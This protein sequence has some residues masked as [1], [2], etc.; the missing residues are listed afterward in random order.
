MFVEKNLV[1][2]RRKKHKVVARSSA[3]AEFKDMAHGLCELIWIKRIVQDLGL[4]HPEPMMLHCDNK[5][6]IAIENNLVQHDRT[7]HVEV[8][9]HFIKN[10]LNQGIISLPFVFSQT[11]LAEIFTKTVSGKIFCSSLDK[12]V[13]IDI[14]SPT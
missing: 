4:R 11:Q 3:E 12:L 6:A 13:I 8:N 5:A 9:R 7:K 10:H 2:W 1:T 14:H